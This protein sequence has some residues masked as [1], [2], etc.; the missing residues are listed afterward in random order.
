MSGLMLF[1]PVTIGSVI[2]SVVQRSVAI[3][4]KL[5][6]FS[7]DDVVIPTMNESLY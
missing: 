7:N 3:S 1:V 2:A 6:R 4:L 5:L